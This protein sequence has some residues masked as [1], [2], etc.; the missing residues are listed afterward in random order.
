[1]SAVEIAYDSCTRSLLAVHW[2]VQ[3]FTHVT[4][5]CKV[6]I[7]TPHTPIQLFLNG[8]VTGVHQKPGVSELVDGNQRA[9]RVGQRVV[10]LWA[11]SVYSMKLDEDAGSE[12]QPAP[13]LRPAEGPPPPTPPDLTYLDS[14]SVDESPQR[15]L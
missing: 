7:H 2:A 12:G 3:H 9:G 14:M 10:S 5:F 13:H 1:M 4:G 6:I 8:H 15:H 11:D